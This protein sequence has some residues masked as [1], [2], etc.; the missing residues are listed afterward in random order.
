[1]AKFKFKSKKRKR[2]NFINGEEDFSNYDLIKESHIELFSNKKAVIE[3]CQKILDYQENY[4]KLKLKKGFVV[5]MG[6][7]FVI[8]DFENE[9]IIICGSV[10]SIE[11]FV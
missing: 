3:S 8:T 10:Y 2:F 6:N 7:D 1:M 4:I 11:F 9:K 5:F